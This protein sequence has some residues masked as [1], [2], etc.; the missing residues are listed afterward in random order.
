MHIQVTVAAA[1]P[2]RL[3]YAATTTCLVVFVAVGPDGRPSSVPPWHPE[4]DEDRDLSEQAERRIGL[5]REIEAAM[6]EQS[7]TDAGTA[8]AALL[9]FLAAPSD[10]NW[11]GKT[12]GGTVMRWIDDAGFVCASGWAGRPVVAAYAGGIRFYR[13]VPIGHVV[14]VDARLLHTGTTS[15]HVSVHVRSADP[16]A[17]H[18]EALTTHCLTVFVALDPAGRPTPVPAWVPR[19]EE[20]RRLADHAQALVAIRARNRGGIA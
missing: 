16:T 15:M 3:E 8:P 2:D 11:G 14:T 1:D 4:S 20:D 18:E 10:V 19:S 7:Y 9:R 12:H 6:G 13:P 5:R 17:P